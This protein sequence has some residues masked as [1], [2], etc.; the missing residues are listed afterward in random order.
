MRSMATQTRTNIKNVLKDWP[1]NTVITARGMLKL[2]ISR[3]LQR[4]YVKSGWLESIGRGAYTMLGEN[5]SLDGALYT[6]QTDLGLSVHQG[7]YSALSEKYGKTH[8]VPYAR[9]TQL[10]AQ[11]G[12]KLPPWLVAK[13]GTEFDLYYTSFLPGNIGLIEY[14]VGNFLVRIPCI[15]RA[16]MEMLYLTPKVHTVQET[17][18]MMELLTTARPVTIQSLLEHCTSIK[19]KR[20]FLYMAELADHPWLKRINVSRIDLGSGNREIEKGGRLNSK[21][22]I[23]VSDP[24]AI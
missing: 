19:V 18:Q 13:Y 20:L 1:R 22:G 4:Y 10:F 11:R 24:R 16:M 12:K 14:D 8:N 9:K 2:G 23:V 3:D 21:Y 7:G 15:E 5:V 6:L 17:Y